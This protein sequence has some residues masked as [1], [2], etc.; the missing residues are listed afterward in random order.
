MFS[1]LLRQRMLVLCMFDVYGSCE[2]AECLL[3]E[4]MQRHPT[5]ACTA[6]E[7][8]CVDHRRESCSLLCSLICALCTSLF[9]PDLEKKAEHSPACC[10]QDSTV[11]I[12]ACM[13]LYKVQIM[14]LSSPTFHLV[15][16]MQACI[17]CISRVVSEI[18][19]SLKV[20]WQL[21]GHLSE[22]GCLVLCG[23]RQVCAASTVRY[24][25]P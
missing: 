23:G 16:L 2:S 4:N 11:L 3:A 5:P 7:L 17:G 22:V 12:N 8:L 14:A 18:K 21:L 25:L 9:K 24:R 20:V 1:C 15:C 19:Q 10:W 13:L 6:A